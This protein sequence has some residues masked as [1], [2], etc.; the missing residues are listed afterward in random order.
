MRQHAH[1]VKSPAAELFAQLQV[2]ATEHMAAAATANLAGMYLLKIR[3]AG[4]WQG[5]EPPRHDSRPQLL[6][7]IGLK[8]LP[9][10][11]AWSVQPWLP[12]TMLPGHCCLVIVGGV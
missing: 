7:I 11:P 6:D 9:A 5:M 4:V 2:P 8:G 12:A 10:G 3:T 1:T